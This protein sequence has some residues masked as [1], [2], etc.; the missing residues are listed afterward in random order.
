MSKTK[1][2]AVGSGP[3]TFAIAVQRTPEGKFRAVYLE[4][5]NKVVVKTVEESPP[6]DLLITKAKAKYAFAKR[7]LLK[8]PWE[9]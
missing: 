1:N 2:E 4:I 7:L 5:E 8:N 6:D 9:A 3:D